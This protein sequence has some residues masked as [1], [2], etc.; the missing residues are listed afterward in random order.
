M[1]QSGFCLQFS[2]I[3]LCAK[4]LTIFYVQ[5]ILCIILCWSAYDIQVY[6]L[7]L[8]INFLLLFQQLDSKHKSAKSSKPWKLKNKSLST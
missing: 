1:G 4:A 3:P 8:N 2:L 7:C 5:Q 6:H